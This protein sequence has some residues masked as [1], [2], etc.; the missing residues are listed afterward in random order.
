MGKSRSKNRKFV[1]TVEKFTTNTETAMLLVKRGVAKEMFKRIIERTPIWFDGD[2]NH[3][4][5]QTRGNWSASQSRPS[6]SVLQ[7]TDKSGEAT[8]A[9]MEKVVDKVFEG[10]SVFLANSV[11]HIFILE[12]GGYPK[13]VERGSWNPTTKA[14]EKRS[15][16]G[17]SNS[18]LRLGP[19]GMVKVTLT[20]FEDIVNM[21]T[22]KYKV[23]IS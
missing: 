8:I 18:L 11:S 5:G 19:A 15:T 16:G 13:S 23:S 21:M 12:D 4:P 9:A 17:W 14:Y 10:K 6:E 7:R 2:P 20:E 3:P 22:R 1:A